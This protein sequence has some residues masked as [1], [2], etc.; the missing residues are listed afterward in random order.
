MSFVQW[1]SKLDT[2]TTSKVSFPPLIIHITPLEHIHTLC[3]PAQLAAQHRELVAGAPLVLGRRGLLRR[4]WRGRRLRRGL[5]R[6][7]W[8]LY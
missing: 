3:E 5:L 8:C 6:V 4:W 7:W 1:F 2:V